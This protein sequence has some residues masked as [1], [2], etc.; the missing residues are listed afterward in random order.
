[1]TEWSETTDALSLQRLNS[2][3]NSPT[4][5]RRRTEF[6]LIDLSF[7]SMVVVVVV[8]VVDVVSLRHPEPN[9]E[10]GAFISY[11]QEVLGTS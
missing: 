4:R 5:R 9:R 7:H 8:V 3:T 2:S 10:K 6:A 1:M 11:L